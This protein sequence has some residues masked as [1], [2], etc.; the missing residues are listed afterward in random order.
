MSEPRPHSRAARRF[1][2]AGGI[3][4]LVSACGS[5]GSSSAAKTPPS[6]SPSPTTTPARSGPRPGAFGTLAAISG[7][8]LE[9]QNPN[10][11][12]TTV[13]VDSSTRITAT[14]AITPS[15][16][17]PGMCAN[18][19]GTKT[20]TGLIDA[21]SVTVSQ[22]S[23]SSCSTTRGPGFGGGFPG[24]Q[25]GSGGF[26][27][28]G[29]P[30]ASAGQNGSGSTAARRPPANLARV[31]GTLSAVSGSTL[32]IKGSTS[33]SAV[34]VTSTTRLSEI[35]V[36][37]LSALKVGDC[38]AAFGSANSI[39]AVTARSLTVTPAGPNGCTGG[40]FAGRGA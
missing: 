1:L 14:A 29:T 32:Q 11:G 33:T 40:F 6:V 13:I 20:S 4:L 19:V 23:G 28:G 26:R 35:E 38:V 24:G 31:D 34:Q 16:L 15:A 22:P 30:N 17:S 36:S 10:T 5:G 27:P 12:Q 2:L 8:N 37:S 3:G 25:R 7:S 9:V 21:N 39:G 18:A